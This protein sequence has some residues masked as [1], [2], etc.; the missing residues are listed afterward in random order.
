[1]INKSAQVLAY[2]GDAVLSLQVR[3]YLVNKGISKPQRLLD[4][5]I[6]FVSA[7]AQAEFIKE[8]INQESLTQQELAIFRRAYNY[9]F[10]SKAKNA[11][12]NSYKYS[13]GLEALWGYWYLENQ[14][15]RLEQMWDKYKTFQK[16]KYETIYLLQ[17]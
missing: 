15:E 2:I 4:E 10:H 17:E 1:M 9:K 5:S 8:V 14:H 6:K 11:D 12:I 7:V 16:E 13:T 3:E